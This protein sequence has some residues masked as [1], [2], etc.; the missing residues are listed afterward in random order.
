MP[1]KHGQEAGVPL[2]EFIDHFAREIIRA[3]SDMQLRQR[4]VW[5]G[6]YAGHNPAEGLDHLTYLGLTE[7]R[8]GF[9]VA[10]TAPGLWTRVKQ[11]FFISWAGPSQ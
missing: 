1:D 6:R 7:V 4:E 11:A 5:L 8:L 2:K 9:R 10:P 3:D